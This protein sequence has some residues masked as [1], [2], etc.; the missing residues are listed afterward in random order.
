MTLL[1]I[2]LAF[3]AGYLAASIEDDDQPPF[4]P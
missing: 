2:I 1:I 3:T 4:D